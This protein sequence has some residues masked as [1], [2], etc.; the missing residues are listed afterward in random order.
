MDV[1]VDVAVVSSEVEE[2]SEEQL[3]QAVDAAVYTAELAVRTLV[4]RLTDEFTPDERKSWVPL[5]AFREQVTEE[6]LRST[7][8][9]AT[10]FDTLADSLD[11]K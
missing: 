1:A 6:R 10:L 11:R 3:L 2:S 4:G 8:A 5:R 7:A 9:A